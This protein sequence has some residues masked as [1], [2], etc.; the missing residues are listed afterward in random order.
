MFSQEA[1]D[2]AVD[3]LMEI[4]RHCGDLAAETLPD[5]RHDLGEM[6]LVNDGHKRRPLQVTDSFRP[7]RAEDHRYP[8]RLRDSLVQVPPAVLLCRASGIGLELDVQNHN[9]E[10]LA[11]QALLCLIEICV[12]P[13]FQRAQFAQF[14]AEHVAKL[15]GQVHLIV[16]H[17]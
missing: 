14:L 1:P 11:S 3:E 15:F 2:L 8:S 7:G 13:D 9:V 16:D 6:A 10:Q 4:P 5:G 17:K 12:D